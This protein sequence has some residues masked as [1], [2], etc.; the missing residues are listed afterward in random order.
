MD[1]ENTNELEGLVNSIGRN[2]PQTETR[3]NLSPQESDF[4]TS[5]EQV[6]QNNIQ[7]HFLE[8]SVV[9]DNSVLKKPILLLPSE[10]K[11]EFKKV[12]NETVNLLPEKD[13]DIDYVDYVNVNTEWYKWEPLHYAAY[14]SNPD[15]LKELCDKLGKDRI[16]TLTMLSENAL[17]VLLEHGT[18]GQSFNVSCQNGTDTRMAKIISKED[19]NVTKS[20]QVLIDAEIDINHTNFWNQTPILIAIKRRYFGVVKLL[21]EK[22]DIDLDSCKDAV[23]GKTAREILEG[24]EGLGKLPTGLGSRLPKEVL[25][26]FLK[27]GDEDNFLEYNGGKMSDFVDK[28]DGDNENNSSCTLLQYCFRR[29]LIFWYKDK[30]NN[31][32]DQNSQ[33][34]TSNRLMNVFCKS[35]MERSI[36]HLINNGAKPFFELRK[37][38]QSHSI[39]E[40]AII[41][42]Y[43]PVVALILSKL[44][45]ETPRDDEV[46]SKIC[47]SLVELLK[48]HSRSIDLNNT[49]AVVLSWLLDQFNTLR[50]NEKKHKAND[51]KA[52]K[53]EIFQKLYKQIEAQLSD[54]LKLGA[55]IISRENQLLLLKFPNSLC[56]T[57]EDNGNKNNTS[58][59]CCIN[60]TINHWKICF[61]KSGKKSVIEEI[62]PEVLHNHLD[63]CVEQEGSQVKINCDSFLKDGSVYPVFDTFLSSKKVKESLNHLVFKILIMRHWENLK[64]SILRCPVQCIHLSV[65][66][67]GIFYLLLHLYIFFY[68][69]QFL[70]FAIC[71]YILFAKK[72][73]VWTTEIPNKIF[74]T[75]VLFTG[76]LDYMQTPWKHE[77]NNGNN[78]TD[79]SL[80]HDFPHKESFSK[81]IF[82][83]FVLFLAIIL[84]NL[85]LGLLVID[86]GD[87]HK[88]SALS[89]Q[90][91]RAGFVVRMNIFFKSNKMMKIL[92]KVFQYSDLKPESKITVDDNDR[93][94]L[95]KEEKQNLDFML[96]KKTKSPNILKKLLNCVKM[97]TNERSWEYWR[98]ERKKQV[99]DKAVIEEIVNN[100]YRMQEMKDE[101]PKND[102]TKNDETKNDETKCKVCGEI[103]LRKNLKDHRTTF[104]H[105]EAQKQKHGETDCTICKE[106]FPKGYWKQHKTTKTHILAEQQ[107]EIS[108]IVKTMKEGE[109]EVYTLRPGSNENRHYINTLTTFLAVR[110][111]LSTNQDFKISV[112]NDKWNDFGDIVFEFDHPKKTIETIRCKKIETKYKYT[113]VVL[114]AE[115]G[116]LSLK[117]QCEILKKLKPKDDFVNTNFKLYT[118]SSVE[119]DKNPEVVYDESNIQK[120]QSDDKESWKGV[121]VEIKQSKSKKNDLF[122]TTDDADDVCTFQMVNHRD[123]SVNEHLSKFQ[124]YIKQKRKP[125]M[126]SFIDTIIKDKFNIDFDVSD[127]LFKYVRN[128]FRTEKVLKKQE[129]CLKVTRENVLVKIAEILLSPFLVV[130]HDLIEE[131]DL[132][133]WNESIKEFDITVLKHEEDIVTKIY[134]GINHVLKQEINYSLSI[135]SEVK[136]D[137]K[138]ITNEKLK[139]KL[140]GYDGSLTFLYLA[141]WKSGLIPLILRAQDHKQLRLICDVVTFLKQ[142]NFLLKF[143]ITTDLKPDH[144]YF[145]EK[146]KVFLNMSDLKLLENVVL[147]KILSKKIKVVKLNCQVSLKEIDELNCDFLKKLSPDAFLNILFDDYSFVNVQ[148]PM[149]NEIDDNTIVLGEDVIRQ[150]AQDLNEREGI[151]ENELKYL[152]SV[153]DEPTYIHVPPQL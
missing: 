56:W 18:L 82:I 57:T 17:H 9:N 31:D 77:N 113:P 134:K 49:L 147:E 89:E 141:L 47:T 152:V 52:V 79:Q 34:I 39:L 137:T 60:S 29:G 4:V 37:F 123:G 117:E 144:R 62:D 64:L 135:L 70:A 41:K 95:T 108:K 127:E 16:N 98:N 87:L 111:A 122:N 20:A 21:L 116:K 99:F 25:F 105:I 81:F 50:T 44:Y 45:V 104:K 80:Y 74:D 12:S 15:I 46:F 114:T 69:I 100:F 84:Q 71:F 53:D 97:K 102:K 92:A 10:E 109:T 43:Y 38:E 66:F 136:I 107:K 139:K 145:S 6:I 88:D 132:D 28:L 51:P 106:K 65:V 133:L 143:V 112:N 85:L 55:K 59:W 91:K 27:S 129:R 73:Q 63:D 115:S 124:M 86:M 61:C 1:I 128:K 3:I 93:K 5:R 72:N 149:T 36:Q 119:V 54:L 2:T 142:E 78:S 8:P 110:F 140:F 58:W 30:A 94:V 67:Y 138:N 148:V 7:E 118:V 125:E 48:N 90:V 126:M 14:A 24:K 150:V 146:L 40:A 120:W 130:P 131:K 68:F 13:A 121:K 42:G 32:C 26:S 83:L 35:G 76:N 75:V 22:S 19:E 151:T 33:D 11:A 101:E 103:V 153:D 23:S 96:T